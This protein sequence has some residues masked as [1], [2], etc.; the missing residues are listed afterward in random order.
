MKLVFLFSLLVSVTKATPLK[1]DI[2]HHVLDADGKSG[3]CRGSAASDKVDSKSKGGKTQEECEVECDSLAN[4]VAYSYAEGSEGGFCII[5]GA[6]QDGSCANY[7][8]E[9]EDRCGSCSA[10]GKMTKS[11][12]GLCNI[13]EGTPIYADASSYADNEGLC[14]LQSGTWTDGSWAEGDWIEPADGWTGD[15]HLTTHVHFVTSVDG[16]DCYDKDRSDHLSKCIGTADANSS[17]QTRFMEQVEGK[18]LEDLTESDCTAGG[19]GCTFIP[20]PVAPASIYFVHSPITTTPGWNDPNVP[21]GDSLNPMVGIPLGACRA[22]GTNIA[23]P[24]QKD[25]KNEEC[26]GT[27]GK[28]VGTQEGC[29]QACLDDPSGTCVSYSHADD[30]WC[31]IHGPHAHVHDTHSNSFEGETW[32]DTWNV[33]DRELKFCLGNIPNNPPNCANS[34]SAKPNPK[35]MCQTLKTDHTRWEAFGSKDDNKHDVSVTVTIT[36]ETAGLNADSL[37][38]RIADLAFW[39]EEDTSFSMTD[40][41][42]GSKLD[43]VLGNL[44]PGSAEPM[45]R[46]M[47]G[48]FDE[49]SIDILMA[50]V[51]PKDV[52]ATNVYAR[53]T[54]ARV[55]PDRV[56]PDSVTPDPVTPAASSA[57]VQTLIGTGIMIL[58]NTLSVF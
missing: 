56:T 51:L 20:A 11:T 46:L 1:P 14:N 32:Q 28:F 7:D 47:N 16:Y 31:V 2:Y 30:A 24:T 54:P 53:V 5:Y 18:N 43:F 26:R 36:G 44:L 55:T 6:G 35:Y 9:I 19:S 3:P 45:M 15:S 33:R 12:C 8:A 27:N 21:I 49:T 50:D 52:K 4:C 34:D 37:R 39:K 57:F 25:C 13:P 29:K 42:V 10:D 40:E 17:C 41:V 38:K 58:I 22:E 48:Q 23:P